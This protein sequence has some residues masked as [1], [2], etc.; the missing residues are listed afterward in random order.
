MRNLIDLKTIISKQLPK[1]PKQYIVRLIMDRQH[2]AM[3]LRRKSQNNKTQIIGGCVFRPF[4]TQKFAE[5]VFLAI[6]TSEQVKGYGTRLMNKLKDH[7]QNEGLNYFLTYAD[8]N[9]IEYFRKQGFTKHPTLSEAR[10]KGYIK[11][12]NG[13]TMMQCSINKNIDY[14]NI[15][16][17]VKSQKQVS[18]HS[19]I[20]VG[21]GHSFG[22]MNSSFYKFTI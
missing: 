19:F 3:I 5:I 22:G 21:F 12:Y 6:A 8:N 17:I 20:S 15:S 11:D 2:E 7:A 10:W 13:S 16:Q 1:M 18:H 9:A 14:V 4:K